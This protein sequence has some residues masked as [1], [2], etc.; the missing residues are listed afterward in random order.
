M[1]KFMRT[2]GFSAYKG[3]QET[4]K[5]LRRLVKEAETSGYLPQMD[6]SR[7]CE[8]RAEVAPGM[9]GALAGGRRIEPE[10]RLS[11]NTIF[12]MSLVQT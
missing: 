3:R 8:L 4:E 9:G 7:Y 12:P 2:I 1:H 11:G 5:L 6:G 10:V